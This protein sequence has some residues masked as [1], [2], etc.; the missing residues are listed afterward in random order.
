MNW[1]EHLVRLHT[2]PFIIANNERID[3]NYLVKLN[4]LF[5]RFDSGQPYPIGH[6]WFCPFKLNEREEERKAKTLV[7][8]DIRAQSK[9]IQNEIT[10]FS[11]IE[12]SH[13]V[14]RYFFFGQRNINQ[15]SVSFVIIG[16]SYS[17]GDLPRRGHHIPCHTLYPILF[18]RLKCFSFRLDPLYVPKLA[19]FYTFRWA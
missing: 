6:F 2:F 16:A 19:T 18:N 13:L 15:S 7:S 17:N 3:Y 12:M 10:L 1:L 9:K 5:F 4:Q 8:V 11:C 14:L